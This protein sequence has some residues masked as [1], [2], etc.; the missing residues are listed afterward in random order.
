MKRREEIGIEIEEIASKFFE[1]KLLD[2]IKLSFHKL[3]YF[4]KFYYYFNGLI[5]IGFVIDTEPFFFFLVEFVFYI[6]YLLDFRLCN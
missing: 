3:M 1:V 5:H 4:V 6:V 2:F